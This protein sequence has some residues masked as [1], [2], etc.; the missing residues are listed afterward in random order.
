MSQGSHDGWHWDT[1]ETRTHVSAFW[2]FLECALVLSVSDVPCLA[3]CPG[4][5]AGPCRLAAHLSGRVAA[6][7]GGRARHP[8]EHIRRVDEL[9]PQRKHVP[10]WRRRRH[11]RPLEAGAT[12]SARTGR[13]HHHVATESPRAA[14][15]G[16]QVVGTVHGIKPP[17]WVA[18]LHFK[19]LLYLGNTNHQKRV[20]VCKRSQRR[21]IS[22]RLS[23]SAGPWTWL[24]TKDNLDRRK[25]TALWIAGKA[26]SARLWW[27]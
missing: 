9:R 24:A 14:T 2:P 12:R 15:Y 26:R 25:G 21:A 22:H 20:V 18:P 3:L 6:V 1:I 8:G 13:R 19:H 5:L 10:I 23:S 27:R 11:R 4:Q 16:A 17:G 7:G